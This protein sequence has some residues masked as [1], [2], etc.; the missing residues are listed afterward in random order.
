[1][2]VCSEIHTK[3]LKIIY[4]GAKGSNYQSEWLVCENCREKRYFGTPEDLISFEP[5]K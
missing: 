5:L 4:K 1:M 3:T 2:N